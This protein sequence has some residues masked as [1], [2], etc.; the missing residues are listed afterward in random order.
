AEAARVTYGPEALHA[1]I[2]PELRAFVGPLVGADVAVHV[3]VGDPSSV[4][5]GVAMAQNASLLVV[6]TQGLGRAARVW[7]GSTTLR[8]LRDTTIAVLGVP[9]GASSTPA[10][11]SLVVGTDFSEASTA[12]L[13][14][15]VALGTVCGVPVTCLHTVPT[16]A[17]HSRWNTEI[18]RSEDAA[19]RAARAQ[20]ESTMATLAP[21]TAVS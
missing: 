11:T 16:V 15:A 21:G 18:K 19:V 6:G 8:L 12:A 4:L 1:A 10:I 17:A 7:F 20:M 14:A 5:G 2:E 9:P 3:G 13:H